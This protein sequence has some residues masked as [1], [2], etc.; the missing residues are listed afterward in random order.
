MMEEDKK[1]EK[2]ENVRFKN[3]TTKKNGSVCVYNRKRVWLQGC[4]CVSVCVASALLV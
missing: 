4:Q 3:R 2:E 1:E